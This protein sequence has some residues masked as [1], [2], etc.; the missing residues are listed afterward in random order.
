MVCPGDIAG[1]DILTLYGLPTSY[2]LPPRSLPSA[3]PCH[4]CPPTLVPFICRAVHPSR[5]PKPLGQKSGVLVHPWHSPKMSLA[6]S[7][8]QH[9]LLYRGELSCTTSDIP[10]LRRQLSSNSL[11]LQALSLFLGRQME[12]REDLEGHHFFFPTFSAWGNDD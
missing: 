1:M 7:V 8:P 3:W 2:Q 11:G 4:S 9:P 12:C 5:A 6:S 10:F